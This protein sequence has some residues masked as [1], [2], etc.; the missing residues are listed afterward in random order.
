VEQRNI[1]VSIRE[2]LS[3]LGFTPDG[4][5][6]LHQSGVIAVVLPRLRGAT[7]TGYVHWPLIDRILHTIT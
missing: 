6:S 2:R 1:L 5:M 7:N 4:T 3:Q